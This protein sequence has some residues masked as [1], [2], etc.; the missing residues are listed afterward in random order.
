MLSY[1]PMITDHISWQVGTGDKAR[2]WEDSWEG[3]LVLKDMEEVDAIMR[4]TE[5][6]WGSKVRYFLCKRTLDRCEEWAW[7]LVEA[8]IC[9]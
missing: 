3:L 5:A 1:K 4:V 7:K 2:F 6:Q 8:L 9:L